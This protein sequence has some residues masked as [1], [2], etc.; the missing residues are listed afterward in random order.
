MSGSHDHLSTQEF[1]KKAG[2]SASTVSKWLRTDKISGQKKNGK[3]IISYE[4]LLKVTSSQKDG[5]KKDS[6]PP[7]LK[8]SSPSKPLPGTK[9]F[10]IQ[11][12]SEMTYLTEFGVKKWLKEGR[13]AGTSD[14]SG[15]PLVSATNLDQPHLK[16]L[17]R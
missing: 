4:E 6:S 16:K 9:N 8:G 10:T 14:K 13:L 3:W 7:P 17:I 1:A 15:K 5:V 12:F 11:E 2:V